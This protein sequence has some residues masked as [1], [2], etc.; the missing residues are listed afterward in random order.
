MRIL[1]AF[2]PLLFAV[3]CVPI[4][5][6]EFSTSEDEIRISPE[7]Y[8]FSVSIH[9]QTSDPTKQPS[10]DTSRSFAIS[11]SNKR[12]NLRVE[13]NE[14][15][16]KDAKS[17]PSPWILDNVSLIDPSRQLNNED[18]IP[19]KNGGWQLNL[20][21][22]GPASRPSIHSEFRVYSYWYCPLIMR[23]Y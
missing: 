21:F 4:Q 13:R 2:I 12:F 3:G 9:T 15:A 5:R 14:F 20:F 8:A 22:T 10:I 1:V 17:H 11:P 6:I 16:Y 18:A 23:P 19:W 7:K